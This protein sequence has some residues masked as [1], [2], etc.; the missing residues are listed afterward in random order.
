M[1][2]RTSSHETP[3]GTRAIAGESLSSI[4]RS[5]STR[6]PWWA[7]SDNAGARIRSVRDKNETAGRSAFAPSDGGQGVDPA[8]PLAASEP[9]AADISDDRA[10]ER[11]GQHDRAE[12]VERGPAVAAALL[13]VDVHGHG[14]VAGVGAQQ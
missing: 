13:R 6:L 11:H 2:S 8:A 14:R 4:S 7:P 9:A 3:G 10:H 5:S 12:R 1:W